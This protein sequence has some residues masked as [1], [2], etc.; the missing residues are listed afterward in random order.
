MSL[1]RARSTACLAGDILHKHNFSWRNPHKQLTF[2]TIALPISL[3]QILSHIPATNT[4]GPVVQCSAIG[5]HDSSPLNLNV[6]KWGF[7]MIHTQ[8]NTSITPDIHRLDRRMPGGEDKHITIQ[9]KPD[10]SNMRTPILSHRCQLS[11]PNL[12][13][14]KISMLARQMI[15][16]NISFLLV[17]NTHFASYYTDRL[18]VSAA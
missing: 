9:V 4:R 17:A 18:I 7:L 6:A 13:H 2:Y 5:T 3:G 14:K 15:H 12:L 1:A 10:R 16:V 11:R 8:A